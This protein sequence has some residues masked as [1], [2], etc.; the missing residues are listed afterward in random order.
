[1]QQEVSRRGME[2]IHL[3]TKPTPFIRITSVED[4]FVKVARATA[5]PAQRRR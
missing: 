1:M 4:K 5:V 2:T 3:T